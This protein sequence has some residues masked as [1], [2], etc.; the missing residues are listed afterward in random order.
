[1]CY[2]SASAKDLTVELNTG[3]ENDQRRGSQGY[4][5]K[6][7]DPCIGIEYGKHKQHPVYGPRSSDKDDICPSQEIADKTYDPAEQSC[8]QIK[9]E[10]LLTSNTLFDHGPKQIETYHVE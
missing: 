7:K 8:Q 3:I 5:A 1:M 2:V 6:D 10:E 4:E 9:E